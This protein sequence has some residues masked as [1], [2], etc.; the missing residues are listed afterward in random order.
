MSL[1][2]EALRKSR[3]KEQSRVSAGFPT[4]KARGVRR[5]IILTIIAVAAAA[6]GFAALKWARNSGISDVPSILQ[7]IPQETSRD[8]TAIVTVPEVASTADAG[9]IEKGALAGKTQNSPAPAL[10]KSVDTAPPAVTPKKNIIKNAADKR[11]AQ[12]EKTDVVEQPEEAGMDRF[13]QKA[14]Q[15]HRDGRIDD[16]I[17]IYQDVLRHIPDHYDA[18]CNLSS[19]YIELADYSSAYNLLTKYPH[20][21]SAD[22]RLLLNLA[23]AETGLG[24]NGDAIGHLNKIN[25]ADEDL[26]FRKYFHLGVASGRMENPEEAL[27]FYRHAEEIRNN[28]PGLLYNLAILYDRLLRYDEAVDYYSRYLATGPSTPDEAEAVKGRIQILRAYIS[29][30]GPG[31]SR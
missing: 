18:V 13:F 4:G 15:L 29:G 26:S 22:P 11:S 5:V 16:A 10:G 24:R 9:N 25:G 14:L 28:H 30:S 6:A 23:I 31:S 1:L 27:A 19:A 8:M 20:S 3:A 21:G 12:P 7:T 2:N 17:A